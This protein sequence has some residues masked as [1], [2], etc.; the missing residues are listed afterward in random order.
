MNV[1]LTLHQLR[2]FRQIDERLLNVFADLCNVWPTDTLIVTDVWR[3]WDEDKDVGGSGVHAAGP[4]YRAIDVR[5]TDLGE[6]CQEKADGV[7]V[8]L[9]E[10]WVYDPSRPTLKVAVS[11]EHGTGKHIHCQVHARTLR[12]VYESR[13]SVYDA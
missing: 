10:K 13:A 3:S 4:P 5:I 8:I 2:E 6:D 1:T 7:A 12:R 9:N 11:K